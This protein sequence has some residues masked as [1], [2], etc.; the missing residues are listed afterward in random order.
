MDIPSREALSEALNSFE[1]TVL[2][3]SHDRYFID[4]VCDRVIE[5]K[6]GRMESYMGNYSWYLTKKQQLAKKKEFEEKSAK[7]SSENKTVRKIVAVKPK[8]VSIEK[9]IKENS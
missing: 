5:I 7:R 6:D 1:G 3:V 4:Q 9:M 2:I 8:A